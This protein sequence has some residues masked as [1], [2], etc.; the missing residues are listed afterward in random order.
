MAAAAED[1]ASDRR[2][3]I[4]SNPDILLSVCAL[5]REQMD[6]TAPVVMRE[7]GALYRCLMA[8]NGQMGAFDERDYFLGETAL[9]AG[10]ASR[11]LGER[12]E[13]EMWLD[14]A[15]AGFR[16]T[17]NPA[18]LMARVTYQRLALRCETGRYKEVAELAPM[19]AATFA[20][21]SM[22]TEEAKC[23]F[24]HGFALKEIG[25]YEVA[26]RVLASLNKAHIEEREPGVVGLAL[27]N[28]ADMYVADGNDELAADSY[29]KALP[30]LQ[31]ANKPAALANLKATIGETFQRQGKIAAAIDAY[32]ASAAD[33]EALGMATWVA[34]MRIVTAQAML[35]AGQSREAEWQILTALPTID[36]E[37]M[38]PEGQVAV[39]LLRESVRQRKTD[40]AALSRLREYLK[41]KN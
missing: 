27:V 23:I 39:G 18:P 21:L 32:R 10:T 19:L 3:D 4:V 13:T 1:H 35:Q 17:V 25:S 26:V 33:Y 5:L 8:S 31:K 28:L 20:R 15:E 29:G 14:R 22:V 40:L 41:A 38:V 37:Q 2:E 34:Y 7:A 30:L 24:L 36:E 9:L 11:L 16:H 6:S 12:S